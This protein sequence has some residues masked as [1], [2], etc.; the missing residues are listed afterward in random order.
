M[1]D[2]FIIVSVLLMRNA[3]FALVSDKKM[4]PGGG[5]I[6]FLKLIQNARFSE[7]RIHK[8]A[9]HYGKSGLHEV[10][11]NIRKGNCRA[12]SNRF[13]KKITKNHDS[14]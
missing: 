10:S 14:F 13:K 7:H 2:T 3:N 8:K 5:R 6:S 9:Q 1:F 11:G 12:E 4:P